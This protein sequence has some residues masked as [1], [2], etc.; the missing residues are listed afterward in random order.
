MQTIEISAS[1]KQLSRLRNGHKVRVSH[2]MAGSGIPLLVDPAKFDQMTRSFTRGSASQ[3]Q[4]SPDELMANRQAVSEGKITGEGIFAGG[5]ANMKIKALR[6][7]LGA[8]KKGLEKA[9]KPFEIAGINPATMGYA[10][11]HDVIAPELKRAPGIRQYYKQEGSGFKKNMSRFLVKDIAVPVA[12]DLVKEGIKS[13]VTG[14]GK[15]LMRRVGRKQIRSVT[16]ELGRA[17]KEIFRD[18]IVP[19]GKRAL[20]ETIREKMSRSQ[21]EVDGA[22]KSLM[23]R[24]GR[25]QIRSVTKEL[26][27]AGKEIFRDVIV[28]ES[29]RALRETIRESYSS[30]GEGLYAGAQQ[31]R[32][33]YAGGLLGPPSRVPETSSLSIGGTL[34]RADNPNLASDAMSANFH[35][36]TQLPVHLQRGGIRFI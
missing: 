24:I 26:G 12:K 25:K 23:R 2:A 17:G 9:G 13:A 6:T 31:G 8:A 3:I 33:M 27:R 4:L 16:K 30:Q 11:G 21:P 28:P 14:T 34:M 10:L 19:E 5:K 35:M 36:N 7:V 29:K 20:R 32:G 18:V 22:G 1:P 15:S